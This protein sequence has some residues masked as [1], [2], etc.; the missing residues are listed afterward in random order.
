MFS[1]NKR[2]IYKM[3]GKCYVKFQCCLYMENIYL[4]YM[5]GIY[6][7]E[8]I[9]NSFV[10][11]FIHPNLKNILTNFCAVFTTVLRQT[12]LNINCSFRLNRVMNKKDIRKCYV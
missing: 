1:L 9:Y 2:I 8:I 4:E 3:V 11:V 7:C 6:Y 5:E 10:C 12:S